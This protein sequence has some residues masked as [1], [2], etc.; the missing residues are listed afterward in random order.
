M[1]HKVKSHQTITNYPDTNDEN[2]DDLL[3]YITI[4]KLLIM[5]SLFYSR[6][7]AVEPSLQDTVPTPISKTTLRHINTLIN[8]PIN[9]KLKKYNPH[10]SEERQN[11][12][13]T[14]KI[15]LLGTKNP[16]PF[17]FSDRSHKVRPFPGNAKNIF[18]ENKQVSRNE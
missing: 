3:V 2:Y 11:A 7:H 16:F 17:S 14:T 18:S 8:N 4:M 9:L 13:L 5:I 6:C 15:T 10:T 1:C 12:R